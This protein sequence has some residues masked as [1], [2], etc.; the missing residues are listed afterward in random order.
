LGTNI[1]QS[2]SEVLRLKSSKLGDLINDYEITNHILGLLNPSFIIIMWL[3][4]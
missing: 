4:Q 2:F 3:L 1:D